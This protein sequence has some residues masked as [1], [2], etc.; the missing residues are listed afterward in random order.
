MDTERLSLQRF[1][2]DQ[3]HGN[4]SKTLRK[5]MKKFLPIFVPSHMLDVYLGDGFELIE[6]AFTTDKVSSRNLEILE[7]VGD[8]FLGAFLMMYIYRTWPELNSREQVNNI[9]TIMADR[10]T[11]DRIVKHL[12]FLKYVRTNKAA[13]LTQKHRSD[14]VE[15]FVGALIMIGDT[16]IKKGI[17]HAI[18]FECLE[19][20]FRLD[21]INWRP[22]LPEIYEKSA[23]VINDWS[24]DIGVPFG[25]LEASHL[26]EGQWLSEKTI[27]S[28]PKEF[29]TH[30]DKKFTKYHKVIR[31]YETNAKEALAEQQIITIAGLEKTQFSTDQERSIAAKKFINKEVRKIR[32]A[33]H[34]LNDKKDVLDSFLKN[35]GLE[36][37]SI[38]FEKVNVSPNERRYYTFVE[39]FKVMEL[40]SERRLGQ[41]ARENNKP[42]KLRFLETVSRGIATTQ[43][44]SIANALDNLD[45]ESFD[46]I[47]SYTEIKLKQQKLRSHLTNLFSSFL[48]EKY[49][50]IFLSE[51]GF[52][53][54]KSAMTDKLVKKKS[55]NVVGLI[56]DN[57]FKTFIN[58]F[59]YSNWPFLDLVD[60][61]NNIKNYYTTERPL[62]KYSKE[63]RLPDVYITDPNVIVGKKQTGQ[64]FKA[65]IGAIV[66]AS[67]TLVA[68]GMGV[69]ICGS[70]LEKFFKQQ[71]WFFQKE[72]PKKALDKYIA[73]FQLQNEWLT[74]TKTPFSRHDA[75]QLEDGTWFASIVI[76]KPNAEFM[77]EGRTVEL[78]D[79]PLVMQTT[80]VYKGETREELA[81]MVTEALNITKNGNITIRIDK[82]KKR[83]DTKKLV[84]EFIATEGKRGGVLP[85][86]IAS[87]DRTK[88]KGQKGYELKTFAYVKREEIFKNKA[89]KFITQALTKRILEGDVP[90]TF[91][92]T[93]TIASGVGFSDSEAI[94][95]ALRNYFNDVEYIPSKFTEEFIDPELNGTFIRVKGSKITLQEATK[96]KTSS[97]PKLAG[98]LTTD[99][100]IRKGTRSTSRKAGE[101]GRKK[102]PTF[103]RKVRKGEKK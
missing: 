76:L 35:Y 25:E 33:K 4:E 95:N 98:F 37:F 69:V 10:V 22:E 75:T 68:K 90:T 21:I 99:F 23:N 16:F 65:L 84:R 8:A 13:G 91:T 101:T 57:Y 15:S 43:E 102:S 47:L 27:P 19:Q 20:I 11:L 88:L 61:M 94:I 86:A 96:I 63:L 82:W 80:G 83:H 93:S 45:N 103:R 36:N 46:T 78:S 71:E 59:A 18:A 24:G 62:E 81:K 74:A 52:E 97:L 31:D 7:S 5:Y 9:Q 58:W 73:S 6:M 14:F 87:R 48:P 26:P 55:V 28:I 34:Q 29:V 44:D 53:F 3:K 30:L 67:E 64:L 50:E 41:K 70:F 39:K 12:G 42:F 51:K 66:L 1:L 77:S 56:G 100:V 17:G 79:F 89:S 54:F 60:H 72:N 40:P 38:S 49:A 2:N 92:I 85:K 32:I